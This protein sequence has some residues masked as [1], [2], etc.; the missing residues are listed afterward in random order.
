GGA[1]DPGR[2]ASRSLGDEMVPPYRIQLVRSS[3]YDLRYDASD[4]A[5]LAV[6]RLDRPKL[7]ADYPGME[8]FHRFDRTRGPPRVDLGIFLVDRRGRSGDR[9][10]ALGQ[11]MG[12]IRTAV[13]F[14][15]ERCSDAAVI[16]SPFVHFQAAAIYGTM[17]FDASAG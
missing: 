5:H 6:C 15:C 16:C 1:D 10:R 9:F 3:D 8:C 7:C 4:A 14:F 12:Y 13:A 11:A 17:I 2:E